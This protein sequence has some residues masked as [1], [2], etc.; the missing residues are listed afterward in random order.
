MSKLTDAFRYLLL[1]E[2][3]REIRKASRHDLARALLYDPNNEH[4]QRLLIRALK[5]NYA[6]IMGEY[7]KRGENNESFRRSPTNDRTQE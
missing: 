7:Q 5:K 3:E 6:Y 1:F 4:T 2:N